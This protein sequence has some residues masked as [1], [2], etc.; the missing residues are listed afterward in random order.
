MGHAAPSFMG[1]AHCHGFGNNQL[2]RLNSEGQLAVGERCVDAD[3]LGIKLIFCRL[4]TVDGPWQYDEQNH[5][6]LHKRIGKC[7]ALHPQNNQLT[8]LPCDPINNYQK[9]QFKEITPKW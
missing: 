7:A 3:G 2:I 4:G 8:L 1:V 9:W 5:V 6:L